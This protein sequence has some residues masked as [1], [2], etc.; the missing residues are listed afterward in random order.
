MNIF[1]TSYDPLECARAL[2]DKRLVKMVL[3]TAQ[4][5]STAIRAVHLNQHEFEV[6]ETKLY[7]PTHENHPC[8]KWTRACQANFKWLVRHGYALAAEFEWRFGKPH[9]SLRIIAYAE[10]LYG[11]FPLGAATTFADCSNIDPQEFS[12]KLAGSVLL[13]YQECLRRKW[14]AD[15]NAGRPPKWTKRAPPL[16]VD[17]STT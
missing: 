14:K 2:D 4:L 7:R 16:W 5:L 10:G 6:D 17:S 8:G 13:R 3:E 1:V 9:A 15:F 11:I 12:G